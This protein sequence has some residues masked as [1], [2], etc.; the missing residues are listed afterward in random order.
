VL[1]VL[2]S[3]V[4]S[5]ARA[6]FVLSFDFDMGK[7]EDFG[8]IRVLDGANVSISLDTT[9]RMVCCYDGYFYSC[10]DGCSGKVVPRSQCKVED[11]KCKTCNDVACSTPSTVVLDGFHKDNLFRV[12]GHLELRKLTLRNGYAQYG[13][14]VGVN[15]EGSASFSECIFRDNTATDFGG[16]L[17]LHGRTVVNNGDFA[18]NTV[19]ACK[20]QTSVCSDCGGGGAV[21]LNFGTTSTFSDCTFT[22]NSAPYSCGGAVFMSDQGGGAT[23]IFHKCTFVRS[24]AKHGGAFAVMP[25]FNEGGPAVAKITSDCVFVKPAGNVT[26]GHNDIFRCTPNQKKLCVLSAYGPVRTGIVT[27]SC[28]AGTVGQAA[29]LTQADSKADQLPPS[30]EVAHCQPKSVLLL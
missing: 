23:G 7:K 5:G 10:T 12:N 27:F 4:V 13:G 11:S 22:D 14:A 26:A 20:N 17:W 1:G 19:L 18:N 9:D 2:V 30:H 15:S 8:Y 16:A 24:T 29:N 28:A 25:G 6:T 3:R 21:D